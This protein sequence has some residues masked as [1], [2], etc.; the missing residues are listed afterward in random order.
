MACSLAHFKG[1]YKQNGKKDTIQRFADHLE[2]SF[3]F[4]GQN[5]EDDFNESVSFGLIY[6]SDAQKHAP[7]KK[8]PNKLFQPGEVERVGIRKH[9]QNLRIIQDIT[10]NHLIKRCYKGYGETNRHEGSGKLVYKIAYLV[11]PFGHCFPPFKE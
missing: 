3:D 8:I 1:L 7:N 10:G 9:L 5:L 6:D 2:P 11:Q 4:W